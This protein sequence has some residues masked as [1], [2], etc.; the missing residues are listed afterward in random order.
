MNL[1]QAKEKSKRQK[2][3]FL[4]F[5][6]PPNALGSL[7]RSLSLDTLRTKDAS[8]RVTKGSLNS[9]S[10]KLTELTKLNKKEANPHSKNRASTK[11][12]KVKRTKDLIEKE[13]KNDVVETTRKPRQNPKSTKTNGLMAEKNLHKFQE[14]TEISNSKF[15]H[16]FVKSPEK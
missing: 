8:V 6:S 11:L 16:F 10:A 12:T 1:A 5:G 9:V 13:A 15:E 4:G 14:V 3:K 2:K 7:G